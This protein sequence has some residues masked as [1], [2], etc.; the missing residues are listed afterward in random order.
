MKKIMFN[1]RYGLTQAIL[2]ERKTM[3]RRLDKRLNHPSVAK[4]SD[5]DIDSKGKRYIA[6]TYSTGLIDVVYPAF[7]IGEEIAIVQRY[8]DICM[9]DPIFFE[10]LRKEA[11]WKNKM[12]VRAEYMPHRISI[13]DI[14]VEQLYDISNEDCIREGVEK[15]MNG[16]IVTGILEN[17]GQN[18]E[19]FES[20]RDAFFKLFA[21]LCGYKAWAWRRN[22]SIYNPWLFAYTFKLVQ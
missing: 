3:T 14:K 15:W 6:I 4:I 9:Y 12:F 7:Q 22:P 19:W 16:Y 11:G 5:W 17:H 1:D 2:D 18:N 21:K 8:K 13:T 10:G 20:P